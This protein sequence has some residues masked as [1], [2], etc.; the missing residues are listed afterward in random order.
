MERRLAA[1]LVADIVGFSHLMETDEAGT[2]ALVQGRWKTVL[3]PLAA[4]HSG[5]VVKFMGDGA[6]LEFSSAVNAVRCAVALQQE[7]AT[8]NIGLPQNKWI[9]LRV[10]VN[11]GDVMVEGDDIFGDGVNV[12]A[13]LEALADP[14]GICV[15]DAVRHQVKGKIEVAFE[16]GGPQQLKNIAEPV[17]VYRLSAAPM[18]SA[19]S[20]NRPR[21]Q[22]RTSIAVLPFDN[23]SGDPEQAYFSDGITED[24][25]AELSK[26]KELQVIARNSS[27][28]F[29]GKAVDIKDLARKLDVQF[30]VEGSVRK[31][32][33]R[34]R[35]TVQLIDASSA[36][37]VWADRYDRE[38]IDVFAIQD[39]ITRS[40]TA[41]VA[42][43][44]QTVLAQRIRARPTTSMT[45]YDCYLRG[46]ELFINYDTGLQSI[47]FLEQ[48]RDLDPNFA[49]PHALLADTYCF[50]HGYD[51]RRE[52]LDQ[53]H[54]A[55]KTALALDPKEPWA[56]YAMGLVLCRFRRL[57]E[58]G[59]YFERAYALNPND[60]YA[61]AVFAGWLSRMDRNDEALT[62]VDEALRRDPYAYDWFWDERAIILA[63]AAR[64]QD[65]IVSFSRMK[66]RNAVPP[67][68]YC[69]QAIC[70]IELSQVEAAR[71]ALDHCRATGNGKMP[72]EIL[73]D[74][75]FGNPETAGRLMASLKRAVAAAA[76]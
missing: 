50:R 26:F 23:M 8:A 5:R 27:F 22:A 46:R 76:I 6:L 66:S 11:L 18:P 32:G 53:A 41:R 62:M 16:D 65:A 4:S 25:I 42:D 7:M 24:I 9:T 28:Q 75:P 39:E 20:D 38:L 74:E 69:Y 10:G 1:I 36:A 43:I 71:A 13:R 73:A 63:N 48:A 70:H 15:S 59:P 49:I 58:A 31:M 30:V 55:A 29:R 45:A 67:R 57:S 35:V 37:H 60:V 51:G 3:S 14:G 33:N 61:M 72:E 12:A 21:T 64:F 17:H 52:H 68:S 54:E 2:L 34:V 44:S 47:P 19:T 56:H 40:I